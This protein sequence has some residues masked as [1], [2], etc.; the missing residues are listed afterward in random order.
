MQLDRT[1]RRI[2]GSLVEKRLST[3]DQY[4]LTMNALVLACNQRSNRDPF[5][6]LNDF[7]VQGCVLGLRQKE[8]LTLVER[9]G[10]RTVRYQERLCETLN[11]GD[12]EAAV[13][14][15][16]MLRGPQT[17]Q[18]LA[19][20]CPRMTPSVATPEAVL[21]VLGK[22]AGRALVERLPKESGRRHLRWAHRLAPP[23]EAPEHTG[24]SAESTTEVVFPAQER[25]ETVQ[26]LHA[27]PKTVH[28][29]P[30]ADAVSALRDEVEML[31]AEV[32]S[33]RGDVASLR[34]RI[35]GGSPAALGPAAPGSAAG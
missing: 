25:R 6:D 27:Q 12:E 3:P 14:A 21:D 17:E 15:E 5:T 2:L 7:E 20:R 9:D 18:E 8:L 32:A 33:L 23:G 22:L 11:L 19:R 30:G 24:S 16:L 35:A 29:M 13:L 10:G 1:I 26:P 34:A 28:P 4:P 31:R